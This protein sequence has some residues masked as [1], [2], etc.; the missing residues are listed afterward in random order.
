MDKIEL[1]E[2][3]EIWEW[4]KLGE[5]ENMPIEIDFSESEMIK[6]KGLVGKVCTERTIGRDNRQ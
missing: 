4:L 5:E 6:K 2:E 1:M 3:I